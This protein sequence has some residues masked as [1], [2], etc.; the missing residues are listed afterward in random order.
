MLLDNAS[1]VY[2]ECKASIHRAAARYNEQAGN[3]EDQMLHAVSYAVFTEDR[4]L[5]MQTVLM[6]KREFDRMK[7]VP[8]TKY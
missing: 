2:K 3:R 8:M 4:A 5:I 7:P 6:C 1:P